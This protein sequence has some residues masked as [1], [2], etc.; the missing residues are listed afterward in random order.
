MLNAPLHLE[1]IWG[2]WSMEHSNPS[3]IPSNKNAVG[4]C[5]NAFS[6]L[7]HFFIHIMFCDGMADYQ[8]VRELTFP[9]KFM[10]TVPNYLLGLNMLGNKLCEAISLIFPGT[11]L[12]LISRKLPGFTFWS[13]LK[14]CTV[15]SISISILPSSNQWPPSTTMS[16]QTDSWLTSIASSFTT[17]W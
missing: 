9:S 11:E 8:T 5:Q 3:N 13:I 17:T 14:T 2:G 6:L 16:F 1:Q 4:Q 10:L 12:E 7:L 15:F